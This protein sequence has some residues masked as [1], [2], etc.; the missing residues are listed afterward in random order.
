M[1]MSLQVRLLG[2]IIGAMLLFFIISVGAAR[3]T[4]QKDL[5]A[6]GTAEVADGASAFAGY[7]D[8]RRDQIRLLVAQDAGVGALRQSLQSGNAKTLADQ[9]STL[10]STSGMSFLVLTDARGNVLARAHG[11]PGTAMSSNSFITRALGGQTISTAAVLPAAELRAE[12]L[13]DQANSNV[14]NAVG[15][16]VEHADKGLAIVAAAPITDAAQ[17]TVGAL[18]GGVL[19]NH[20]YDLV[21]QSTRALGGSTALLEGDALVASTILAPS[22]TRVIDQQLPL[23]NEVRADHS[24]A[25]T[26][27]VGGTQYLVHV[28]PILDDENN[29][30]GERWYG[31][32]MQQLTNI[33]NHTTQALILWGLIA[34][35]IALA[36]AIPIVQRLANALARRSHQVRDAAKDLGV[37]IVGSEVSG[38]HV[39]STRTAVEK[40][41]SL[42]AQLAAA[43]GANGVVS[44]LKT[45]NDELYGDVIVIDTLSQEMSTR[46]QQAVTRV[47]E[48]NEVAGGL[49]KLVTGEAN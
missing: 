41:A 46:M 1:K 17:H 49:N 13:T 5:E 12:G 29:L 36:L 20:F 7:W 14:T 42:I 33:I 31:V 30:V 18:Y 16:V 23:A 44:A 43:P 11:A 45:L 39:A 4:M 35:V 6:R 3:F 48:L 34:F 25:G 9:L 28:D 26:D 15:K 19:F 40:S 37:A 2:T 24:Y 27:T 47:K 32:P 22:G 8:S 21:D 38:D 10:A